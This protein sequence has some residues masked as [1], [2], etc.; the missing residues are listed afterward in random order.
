VRLA[1]FTARRYPIAQFTGPVSVRLYVQAG[2]LHRVSD[3]TPVTFSMNST[4]SSHPQSL[5]N[6]QIGQ[7]QQIHWHARINQRYTISCQISASS[8]YIVAHARRKTAETPKS[9]FKNQISGLYPASSQIRTTF[10]M[11]QWSRM[12]CTMPNFTLI[13]GRRHHGSWGTISSSLQR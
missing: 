3:R 10:D 9:D 1:R 8:V 12:C 2:V 7:L 11:K 4:V 5:Q 13:Y 6:R